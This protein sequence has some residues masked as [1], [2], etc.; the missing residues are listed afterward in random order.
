DD[1]ATVKIDNGCSPMLALL[2]DELPALDGD[3]VVGV[4]GGATHLGG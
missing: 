4:Y 3:E 1:L 2:A